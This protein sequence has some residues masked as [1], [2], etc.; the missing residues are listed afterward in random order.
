M[1]DSLYLL[2]AP[3]P[4]IFSSTWSFLERGGVFM[5]PL[6][7]T[8]VAG[9]TALIYKSLSLSRARI[10][11]DSLVRQI[12][13]FEE[14]AAA[15]RIAPVIEEFQRGRS[16]LARLA[17]VA[18]Q[19]RGKPRQDIQFAVETRAREETTRMHAG[20]G[21][22]DVVITI[23]PLLGL[24]GTASGLVH[25]FDGLSEAADYLVIARGIAEAMTTTI[26]GLAIAVPGIIAHGFF[27]RRIDVLTSRLESLL[28]HLATA[29][30]KS[31]PHS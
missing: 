26:F 8:S 18:Y 25:I 20:I 4:D 5:V 1:I 9:V 13:S 2:V 28:A 10:I 14:L 19:Q 29:C 7:L 16:T 27:T 31:Q 21:V 12:E 11:P 3:S 6:G 22:L 24:L 15:D 23:A 30:Q 17:A